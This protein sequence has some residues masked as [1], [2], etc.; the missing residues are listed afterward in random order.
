MN[1]LVSCSARSGELATGRLCINNRFRLVG[2]VEQAEMALL[3]RYEVVS[4]TWHAARHAAARFA[5]D[6]LTQ[7]GERRDKFPHA[8]GGAGTA[9]GD[10]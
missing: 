10:V 7:V 6:S 5:N 2:N 8:S 3:A 4:A 9:L 1:I